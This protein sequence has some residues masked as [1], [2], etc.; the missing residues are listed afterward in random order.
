MISQ[1]LSQ[2]SAFLCMYA[3][4]HCGFSHGC[5]L[6]FSVAPI[7]ALLLSLLHLFFSGHHRFHTLPLKLLAR[8]SKFMQHFPC[9]TCDKM[10][11][12]AWSHAISLVMQE[13]H[14]CS[15][16]WLGI[17]WQILSTGNM[18]PQSTLWRLSKP[19]RLELKIYSSP[20]WIFD[21]LPVQV[22]SPYKSSSN[23]L[24]SITQQ[25]N[26]MKYRHVHEYNIFINFTWKY[27][28]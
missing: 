28:T 2:I 9:F 7:G 5:S 15:G 14:R 26:I 19:A 11:T 13:K 23:F 25:W 16:T 24:W 12:K 4:W 10:I 20:E 27:P 17:Y 21:C 22:D 1:F 8:R 18:S 6:W 3:M